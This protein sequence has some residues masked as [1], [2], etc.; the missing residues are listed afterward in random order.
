MVL[1]LFIR[2]SGEYERSNLKLV[3]LKKKM[4]KTHWAAHDSIGLMPMA[5]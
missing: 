3:P 2:I 4:F 1:F 5:G